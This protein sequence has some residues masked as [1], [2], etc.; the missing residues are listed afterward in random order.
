MATPN[1]RA[2]TLFFKI[3]ATQ[4]DAK[5]SFTYNLGVAKKEAI[6]GSD[7]VHGYKEMPKAPF[8]DGIITDSK[9]VDLEL[10]QSLDG[11]TVTLELANGKTVVLSD[12]WYAHDGDV[13]TE[14]GEIPTRFEGKKCEEVK[15]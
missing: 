2:G 12:G 1:R 8:I 11:V 5:G 10:L 7:G 15:G 4:Y 13:T 6:V 9:D 14:E 3:D